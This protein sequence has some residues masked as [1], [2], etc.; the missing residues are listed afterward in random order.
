MFRSVSNLNGAELRD[1][2]GRQR[3]DFVDDLE[4]FFWVY[5]WMITVH[6]GP[7]AKGRVPKQLV[8]NNWQTATSP[9][10][11]SYNRLALQSL[12]L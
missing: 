4:S 6:N 5:A 11:S 10:Y 9:T 12:R 2:K 8:K 1:I 7:G 3:H